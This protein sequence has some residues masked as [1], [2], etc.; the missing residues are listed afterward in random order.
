MNGQPARRARRRAIS[1][2]S[3]A[4]GA[5]HQ[6]IFGKHIFGHFGGEFLAADAVAQGYGYRAFCGGLADDV[7]VQL[8]DN[9]ARGEFVE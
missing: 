6:N 4:G 5:D 2:F 7:F 9:F 1:V 3:H 8:D